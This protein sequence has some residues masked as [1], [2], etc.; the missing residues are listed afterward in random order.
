[1]KS[2]DIAVYLDN[3]KLDG[4]PSTIIDMTGKSIKIIRIGSISKKEIMEVI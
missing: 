1:L 2:S 4:K 3:G